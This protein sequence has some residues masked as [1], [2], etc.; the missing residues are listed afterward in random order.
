MSRT[1][2]TEFFSAYLFVL[3][4]PR[5]GNEGNDESRYESKAT[6]VK[7]TSVETGWYTYRALGKPPEG[8]RKQES[9]VLCSYYYTAAL[10]SRTRTQP[11]ISMELD[12][13]SN[14]FS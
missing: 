5:N 6:V 8:S 14:R 3:C 4:Q 13:D 10:G 9:T 2:G 11:S 1:G 12:K 7:G